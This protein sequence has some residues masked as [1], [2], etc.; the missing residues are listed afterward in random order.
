[1]ECGGPPQEDARGGPEK[2]PMRREGMAASVGLLCSRS[3][4]FL[5]PTPFIVLSSRLFLTLSV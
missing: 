5:H 4:V 3:S 2:R 1:M